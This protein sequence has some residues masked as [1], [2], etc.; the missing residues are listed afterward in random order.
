MITHQS[1]ARIK[2]PTIDVSAVNWQDHEGRIEG[3]MPSL[4]EER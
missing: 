1:A 4:P 3:R 2:S